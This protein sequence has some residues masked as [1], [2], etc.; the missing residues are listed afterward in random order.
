VARIPYLG[1]LATLI[2]AMALPTLLG[3][4]TIEITHPLAGQAVS[5]IATFSALTRSVNVESAEFDLGSR[6]IGVAKHTQLSVRWNTGYAADGT[7]EVQVY[8]RNNKGAVVASAQRLFSINNHG[9]SLTTT[10]P[11]LSKT[12]HGKAVLTISGHDSN[13]FPAL[14]LVQLDGQNRAVAWTDHAGLNTNTVTVGID[15]T[16]VPNGKHELSIGMHCD[17]L[18]P[19]LRWHNFGGALER[20]VNIDNG[21]TFME[22]IANYLH[23]YLRPGELAQ[24]TCRQVFTDQTTTPCIAPVWSTSDSRIAS[25]SPSGSLK[26]EGRGFATITLSTKGTTTPVHVWVR[27]NL[28]IPHFGGSGRILT[29]YQP[30]QSIFFVAPFAINIA[31]LEQ[32]PRLVPLLKAA[33]I[34]TVSQGFYIN[35]RGVG[36][37]LSKWRAHYDS[38]RGAEWQWAKAN[39]F[40]VYAVG[41]DVAR[42][43]GRNGDAYNTVS[44]TS[45]KSAVQHA[46]ESLAG[47]GIAIGVDMVDEVASMWG[48]CPTCNAW[49]PDAIMTIVAWL[50]GASPRVPISWP[51]GGV[52]NTQIF[53]NWEG[54]G[55]V[56]DHASEYWDSLSLRRSYAW[57]MG[58]AEATYYM[59]QIFYQRQP[60]VMLNRPQVLLTC[61][62]SW[63]YTK[64]T[65]GTP[66]YTPLKD[67]ADSAGCDGPTVVA[68][69]MTAAALG[70][71]GERAYQWEPT[72]REG[73]RSTAPAASYLQTGA[74]PTALDPWVAEN[75]KALSIAAPLLT[76]TFAPY[77]L[78]E[79]LNSPAYGRNIITAARRSNSGK[80]LMI[81]NGNDWFRELF[82]DLLPFQVGK[83]VTRYAISSTEVVQN[84]L[85]DVRDD[86]VTLGGGDTVVY[87]F[88]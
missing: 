23:V 3:A 49:Q 18:K 75:W 84:T 53:S 72:T 51:V 55:S 15:T 24:L 26:A 40:H 58:V 16:A 60:Y 17:L 64:E 85:P 35:P 13:Y 50:R 25:I 57:S 71:A 4:Q 6:R 27:S 32:N 21:H 54:E 43:P 66:F 30:G 7:Y 77:L 81:I 42:R 39:G 29:A 20:V 69:M 34:N 79:A 52:A 10:S 45:G 33:G 5:G 31:E 19:G 80:M 74:N 78:G 87:L 48:K 65:R 61:L 44:W 70:A 37:D 46:M 63:A 1:T 83:R 36:A 62:A 47:S 14:W 67:L 73:A 88:N 22:I 68:E 86:R 76:R 8:G 82:V 59:A 2:G 12:L 9:N 56:S 41:D 11:D 38:T 28:N